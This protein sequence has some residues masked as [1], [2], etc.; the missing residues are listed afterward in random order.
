MHED[1]SGVLWIGTSGKGLIQTDGKKGNAKRFFTNRPGPYGLSDSF[2]TVICEGDDSTLWIGSAN[3][4]NHYN[5]KTRTFTRYVNDPKNKTSLTKGV[6]N[7]IALDK[8]GSLWLATT[9]GLDRF[10]I[11]SGLFTQYRNDP[12]DS[13][14]LGGIGVSSLLKDHSGNLWAGLRNGTVSLFNS[15]TG[16]FQRFSYGVGKRQSAF[17][18]VNSITEDAENIIWL[19]TSR[20][21]QKQSC[22]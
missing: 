15:Q 7:A 1:V 5:R 12:K 20:T 21:L 22:S 3:G 6:A 9:E 17:I 4:L 18:V 19:G 8:P 14:S 11:K 13:T 16:K 10:D 2:I